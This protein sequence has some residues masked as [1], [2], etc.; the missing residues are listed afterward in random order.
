MTMMARGKAFEYAIATQLRK[1]LNVPIADNLD[2]LAAANFYSEH[3][4]RGMDEA[5]A[6]AVLFLHAYDRRFDEAQSI[7]IQPDKRGAV[8]D[9]RDVIV[10]LWG[11]EI[12]ISAKNNHDAVKHSRVSG[13]IDFG[14]KWADYPVSERYWKQVRP[15]FKH[16]ETLRERRYMFRHLGNKEAEIYLPILTAFEDEFRRLAQAFGERFIKRVFQ[17]LVGKEDFYKVVRDR[18]TVSIQS[19]NING[20]LEWG[21]R[22]NIPHGIDQIQRKPGTRNTILVSFAGGWQMSFR[23]H[24]ARAMV[25]PSLKFDIRFVALPVSVA[26]HQIPLSN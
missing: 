4:E 26:S 11:G 15:V 12:G 18:D 24:N 9:V 7:R 17:Y 20:T 25:E 16:M 8:G 22:W 21:R 5:A 1:I 10:K 19:Y 14:K 13:N 3:G 23:L 6:E 2:T